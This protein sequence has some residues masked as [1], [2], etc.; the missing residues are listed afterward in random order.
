MESEPGNGKP[1]SD[2]SVTEWAAPPIPRQIPAG[3]NYGVL[4]LITAALFVPVAWFSLSQ[5]AD[6]K[7]ALDAVFDTLWLVCLSY[8]I[9]MYLLIGLRVVLSSSYAMTVD[10]QGIGWHST[11]ER[12][13]VSWDNIEAIEPKLMWASWRGDAG[14]KVINPEKVEV[15]T[16][17]PTV[18]QRA[19]WED[20]IR[21]VCA[22]FHAIFTLRP[23]RLGYLKYRDVYGRMALNRRLTGNDLLTSQYPAIILPRRYIA[24]LAQAFLDRSRSQEAAE[25]T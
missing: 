7:T 4:S 12:V 11:H 1:E 3:R 16:L 15:E 17:T 23:S 22:I 9:P 2:D 8:M 10:A 20:R 19:W 18:R 21:G 25:G 5:P 13:I 14:I 24:S 6:A